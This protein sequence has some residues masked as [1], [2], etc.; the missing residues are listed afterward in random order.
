MFAAAALFLTLQ[1]NLF[2]A[3]DETTWLYTAGTGGLSDFL[4]PDNGHLLLL[5]YAVARGVLVVFGSGYAAFSII[6]VLGGIAAGGVLFAYGRRRV[7][8][9]LALPPALLILFFGTGWPQLL[10]GW[11]GMGQLW[12]LAFGLG[13]LTLVELERRPWD[14]AACLLLVLALASFTTGVAFTVGTAVAI[15]LRPGR[16]RR[17]YVWAVPAVLYV[18]WRVWAAAK[19]G[20]HQGSFSNLLWVPG[21][22]V[23][24]LTITVLG[25][26]G[27]EA[28]VAPGQVTAL[29]LNGFTFA[30]LSSAIVWTAAVAVILLFVVT[31]VVRRGAGRSLASAMAVLLVL[32]AAQA[33]GLSPERTAGELRYLFADAF[34]LLIVVLA[35]AEGSRPS[36]ATWVAIAVL[37]PAAVIGMLPD[38]KTYRG[39]LSSYSEDARADLA[40]FELGGDNLD[41]TFVPAVSAPGIGAGALYLS[42]P[43]Y[44]QIADR[45]GSLAMPL[46]D[47]ERAPEDVRR[48]AD[49]VYARALGVQA[50]PLGRKEDCAP[51]SAGTNSVRLP[52][53]GGLVR[54]ASSSAYSLRRLAAG[55]GPP[56]GLLKGGEAARI[57]IPPDRDPTPWILHA[58]DARRLTVCPLPAS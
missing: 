53:G 9:L 15:A 2:Y 6:G 48:R 40:V 21:Y 10:Q 35:A 55:F 30:Q 41:P 19:Y 56:L 8:P 32:W 29:K 57:V 38:L 23:D 52:R 37:L 54:S 4:R 47:L 31:A 5:P 43:A 12:P 49:G 26:F 27:R 24:S 1:R 51:S 58:S 3:S 25:A 39:E 20:E 36:V 16:W 33:Y 45:Y 17:S 34:V 18:V 50:V 42:P 14:V 13:A 46:D 22:V 44:S 11:M 28:L 7:G